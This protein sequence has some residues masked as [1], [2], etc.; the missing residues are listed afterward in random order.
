MGGDKRAK[1][2]TSPSLEGSQ[3]SINASSSNVSIG[4]TPDV[5]SVTPNSSKDE[6]K[7]EVEE[8]E[9]SNRGP[10]PDI[11]SKEKPPGGA[12]SKENI[13]IGSTEGLSSTGK[14]IITSE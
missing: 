2:G 14:K 9:G 3:Q 13:K 8:E 4:E 5:A 10:T 12:S 7:P 6:E 1:S 11:I